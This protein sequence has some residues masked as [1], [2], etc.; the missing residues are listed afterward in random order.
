MI[1]DLDILRAANIL[2]KRHGDNGSLVVAQ[3]AAELLAA[4]D[5][6]GCAVWKRIL[7]AVGELTRTKLTEGE[8]VN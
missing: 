1:D 3:R 8:R 6:E 2:I 4:G 5:P 7:R